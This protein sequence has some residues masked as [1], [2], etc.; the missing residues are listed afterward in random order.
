[1][2]SE[3]TPERLISLQL[4]DVLPLSLQLPLHPS[5]PVT[6]FRKPYHR[7]E[8]SLCLK[9]ALIIRISQI[10]FLNAQRFSPG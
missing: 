10:F 6:S 9:R 3:G 2:L 1:M 4:S 7:R 8:T 5:P